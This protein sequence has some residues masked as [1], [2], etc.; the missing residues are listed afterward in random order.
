MFTDERKK[1]KTHALILIVIHRQKM[2]KELP[3]NLKTTKRPMI[4]IRKKA[5]VKPQT[6]PTP[7]HTH[8]HTTINMSNIKDG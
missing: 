1:L 2:E 7:T 4:L 3:V 5:F 6:T 8:T